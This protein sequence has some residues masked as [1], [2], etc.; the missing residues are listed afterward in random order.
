MPELKPISELL[1]TFHET[2]SIQSP[3]LL[4][5]REKHKKLTNQNFVVFPIKS[6][7]SLANEAYLLEDDDV[8][9]KEYK[10]R[11]VV[12]RDKIL[13]LSCAGEPTA[14]IPTQYQMISLA[15]DEAHCLAAGYIIFVKEGSS[16]RIEGID[17]NAKGYAFDLHSLFWPLTILARFCNASLQ[18]STINLYN[19]C[20][21]DGDDPLY[22]LSWQELFLMTANIQIPAQP[23][24]CKTIINDRPEAF[25][26]NSFFR[27]QRGGE[28]ITLE[29]NGPLDL[30]ATRHKV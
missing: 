15:A 8:L 13:W 19:Q 30:D 20:S 1:K 27:G 10:L 23:L 5:P 18:K 7:P 21:A 16:F 3:V 28:S 24:T 6:M 14:Y 29:K 25:S 11:Y 26:V 17:L 22:S 4:N 2:Y 12:D 9:S